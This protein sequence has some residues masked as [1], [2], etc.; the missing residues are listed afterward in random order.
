[1]VGEGELNWHPD[2]IPRLKQHGDIVWTYGGTPAVQNVSTEITL[3]PLRS[4]ING[5]DGFVRWQT[6]EPGSDPWF[7][8]NGGDLTLV[9][10]GE[11]FNIAGPIP[12]IRL[13]LQRNCLQDLALLD[14]LTTGDSRKTLGEEVA[15][16]FNHTQ[17]GDWSDANAKLPDKPIL[18]WN[19]A[20]F[21][22][23]LKPYEAR[24]ANIDPGAWLRVRDY[25]L[26][27]AEKTQ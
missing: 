12:S 4:W 27:Q 13:K 17:I 15:R 1:V 14:A 11:R 7:H 24:F 3:N 19:N 6:V 2:E 23:A 5:V 16:R 25:T 26:D 10:P 9:Y 22:D 8:L 21:A 20:D 18:D